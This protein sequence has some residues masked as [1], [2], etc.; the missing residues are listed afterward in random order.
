ME[1]LIRD[2]DVYSPPNRNRKQ[3]RKKP[4]NNAWKYF[5]GREIIIHAFENGSFPLRKIFSSFQEEDE[6]QHSD[7][8][9]LTE[10]IRVTK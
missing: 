4:L 6:P 10:W 1:E 5:R 3:P 7:Q 8:S 9:I 2:L